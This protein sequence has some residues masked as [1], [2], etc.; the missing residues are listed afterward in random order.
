[1][2]FSDRHQSIIGHQLEGARDK[3]QL[4]RACPMSPTA[5]ALLGKKIEV[6]QRYEAATV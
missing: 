2:W 3:Y 1:L 4:C 5:P 6:Y